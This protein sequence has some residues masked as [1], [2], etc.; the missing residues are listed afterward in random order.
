MQ[1][2]LVERGLT[3]REAEVVRLIALGGSPR[4][5]A[6][7]LAVSP[8]TVQKHLERAYRKLGVTTRSAAAARAWDLAAESGAGKLAA[9]QAS[10]TVVFTT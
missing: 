10:E 8:R 5:A 9:H 3:G 2:R 7:Q 1:A 4:S 6:E